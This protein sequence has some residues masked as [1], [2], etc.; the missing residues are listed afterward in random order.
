[1]NHK[2]SCVLAVLAAAASAAA[3]PVVIVPM[4]GSARA[5][6]AYSAAIAPSAAAVAPGLSAYALSA[7]ALSA[8]LAAP[9]LPAYLPAS[10]PPAA[11]APAP[12]PTAASVPAAPLAAAPARPAI[13][14]VRSLAAPIPGDDSG[15]QARAASQSQ[16][17]GALPYSAPD[18]DGQW[19]DRHTG[20]YE[21]QT[22]KIK[23]AYDLALSHPLA[24]AIKNA[25]PRNTVYRV[26]NDPGSWYLHTSVR[27]QGDDAEKA[28]E[29]ALVVFNRNALQ[30]LSPEFL[31]AKLASMWV[32]HMYRDTMPASAEKTYIEG[33]VLTR[34]FMGLTGSTAQN[35]NGAKDYFIDGTFELYRHFYN[36]IQGFRYP[37][38]RQGPYFLNKIMH[39]E[40]DPSIDADARG[41]MTLFQRS[42]AG[43]ISAEQAQAAQQRFDGFVANEQH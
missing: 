32:R 16:F 43:Q 3:A 34:V 9:S 40:G 11:A 28:N 22:T 19:Y 27:T 23:K 13:A 21:T 17:D 18:S 33:S 20:E 39:A 10:V 31:A 24:A 36:W 42:S 37:N 26:D 4:S 15:A 2:I 6:P 7:P 41:R 38:V 5:L 1:M 35:W 29:A 30:Q 25:L 8:A 12:V 14:A